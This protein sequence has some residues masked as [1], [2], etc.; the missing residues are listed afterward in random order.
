MDSP[1]LHLTGRQLV[2]SIKARGSRAPISVPETADDYDLARTQEP[3]GDPSTVIGMDNSTAENTDENMHVFSD[4]IYACAIPLINTAPVI[5][6]CGRRHAP[7]FATACY[8]YE[9]A[10]FQLIS[11]ATEEGGIGE[12]LSTDLSI[13][14]QSAI[15]GR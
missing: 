6:E 14:A 12:V 3:H 15:V 11:L 7:V 4:K 5:A 8:W 2:K 9:F 1:D 13:T 10:C